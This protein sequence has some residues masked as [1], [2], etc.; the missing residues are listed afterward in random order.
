VDIVRTRSFSPFKRGIKGD[1]KRFSTKITPKLVSEFQ[2]PPFPPFQGG[3]VNPL[4]I[5]VYRFV[6]KDKF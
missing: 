1:F 5:R 3:I 6:G 4:S 2:N